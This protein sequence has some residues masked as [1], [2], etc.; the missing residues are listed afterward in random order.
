MPLDFSKFV[1]TVLLELSR[2][3]YET[4]FLRCLAS[5]GGNYPVFAQILRDNASLKERLLHTANRVFG[6]KLER[7]ITSTEVALGMIG[8]I[9]SRNYIAATMIEKSGIEDPWDNSIKNVIRFALEGEQA[10][11]D[12]S[13]RYFAAGLVFDFISSSMVSLQERRSGL[14]PA[15][16]LA[17][18]WKHSL[19]VCSISRQLVNRLFPVM[20]LEKEICVHALL[21]DVGKAGAL[22][23]EYCSDNESGLEHLKSNGFPERKIKEEWEKEEVSHDSMGH[24]I[25]W[26]LGFLPDTLWTTLYHHQP[27]LALR[28]GRVVHQQATLIWLADQICRYREFHHGLRP[29][30]RMVSGWFNVV[31]P[32][33]PENGSFSSFKAVVT[34]L[35]YT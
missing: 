7:E 23:L 17:P 25:L 22:L 3:K 27:Y 28:K 18:I 15:E 1:D 6:L 32:I 24:L 20:D 16:L 31:K 14:E 5:S 35:V 26:A 19:Q 11:G 29:G 30:D 8:F 10:G 9:P 13:S 34:S 21:H 4:D 12:L 2:G 33:L